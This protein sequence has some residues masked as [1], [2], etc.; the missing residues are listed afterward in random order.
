MK[1]LKD[2]VFSELGKLPVNNIDENHIVIAGIEVTIGYV[3]LLID[4]RN[5]VQMAMLTAIQDSK[6]DNN[7]RIFNLLFD[8]LDIEIPVT[9]SIN[10]KVFGVYE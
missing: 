10:C 6:I 3:C 4:S 9:T 7:G 8:N 1:R 2:I 5:N